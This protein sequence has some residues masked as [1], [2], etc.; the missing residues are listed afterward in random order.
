M[1]DTA[2]ALILLLGAVISAGAGVAL[3][4]LAKR[5]RTTTAASL[6]WPS[7]EGRVTSAAIREG[8]RRVND[9][10]MTV[11]HPEVA[12]EFEIDG[13]HYQG[14]HV[15]MSQLM[16]SSG[17]MLRQAK[18][19]EIVDRYP[20]GSDVLVHYDPAQPERAVLV[21]GGSGGA[22]T[23]LIGA[24]ALLVVGIGCLIGAG[25]VMLS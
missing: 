6:S 3:L 2:F 7:V 21:P 8:T 5:Y 19:E 17:G 10:R 9:N 4:L 14:R 15:D 22:P 25:A 20:I 23:T 12:Y 13:R 18:A 16:G 24:I 11:Y 1:S